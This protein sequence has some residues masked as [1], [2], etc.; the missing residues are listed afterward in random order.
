MKRYDWELFWVVFQALD[1]IQHYFWNE[2][3]DGEDAVADF[4]CHIDYITGRFLQEIKD[5]WNVVILSDHGFHKIEGEIHINNL[6]EKW[7]YLKRVE[8][9]PSLPRGA[10]HSLFKPGFA[11]WNKLSSHIRRQIG[12]RIPAS[13]SAYLRELKHKSL[14]R[15][16][17]IDWSKTQAFSFGYM[18]RIYIHTK[19]KY[20]HGTVSAVDGYAKLRE[21]II[22]KLKSLQDPHTGQD[23]IDKVFRKEEIYT[24]DQFHN[25]PDIVFIP[26]NYEYMFFGDFGA[27]WYNLPRNRVADHDRE[28]I[29]I[30]RG[31]DIRQVRSVKAEAVDIVPTL[32]YL[33]DLP[34]LPDMD[35]HVLQ[36]AL[37]EELVSRREIRTEKYVLRKN[38]VDTLLKEDD[39]QEIEKRLRDMGYL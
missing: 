4:Y 29:L 39:Q 22:G 24:G 34:L 8:P 19:E 10:K 14:R 21:E 15:H 9:S 5:K 33:N 37:V 26:S 35:G 17:L 13:I 36:E 25:A 7:G 11:L 31:K 20:P 30:M 32:L 16:Q 18:G 38:D 3:I 6:L 23:I 27:D 28:G 12:N 2:T 1:W